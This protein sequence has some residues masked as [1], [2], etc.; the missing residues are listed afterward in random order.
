MNVIPVTDPRLLCPRIVMISHQL[1][2]FSFQT[3]HVFFSA[4]L[5]WSGMNCGLHLL[6]TALTVGGGSPIH[7]PISFRD[8]GR[9]PPM[10]NADFRTE[11]P[12]CILGPEHKQ[13]FSP[14]EPPCNAVG[15]FKPL[16]KRQLQTVGEA[17]MLPNT[18][19]PV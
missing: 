19:A 15:W 3:S 10:M 13:A 14:S 17:N 16:S 2:H 11:G 7:G 5:N 4:L 6:D 9:N 18:R 1:L 12:I 8:T